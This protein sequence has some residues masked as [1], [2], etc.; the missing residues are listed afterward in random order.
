[1]LTSKAL[2]ILKE[3]RLSGRALRHMCLFTQQ[4]L[5]YTCI[6]I[7]TEIR[8]AKRALDPLAYLL[9]PIDRAQ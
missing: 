9:K 8:L 6:S 7:S 2:S 1:M 3:G 4:R 5:F